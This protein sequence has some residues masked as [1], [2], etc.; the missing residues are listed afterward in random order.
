MRLWPYLHSDFCGS[1]R[2]LQHCWSWH[3]SDSPRKRFRY[4]LSGFSF[5]GSYLHDRT[6]VVTVNDVKCSP[7]LLTCGVPQGSVLGPI[8]LILYTQPLPDVISRHS[9][10][11]HMFA[12]DSELYKSDSPSEVFTLARTI[13]SCVSDVKVW[14]VQNKLQLNDDKTEI[15]LIGSAPGTDDLLSSLCVGQSVIFDS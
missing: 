7:S 2:C 9:V 15:L 5:F 4:F 1:K 3:P 10:S 6:H 12:D 13:E 11:R 14:V 8:L